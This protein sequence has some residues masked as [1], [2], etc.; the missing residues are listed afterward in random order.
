[1]ASYANIS[2]ADDVSFC[3]KLIIDHGVAAI[4]ISTFYSDHKDQKLIR[5]CFAKDNLTL[6]LAAKKLCDI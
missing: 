5:F 4:P 3:K 6:E 2:N 1:V